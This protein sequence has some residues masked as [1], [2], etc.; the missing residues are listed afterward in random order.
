MRYD[1]IVEEEEKDAG[2]ELDPNFD[3]GVDGLCNGDNCRHSE[4]ECWD[5]FRLAVRS[6]LE[7]QLALPQPFEGRATG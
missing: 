3:A 6:Q 1:S 7:R 5:N 2:I 4:C